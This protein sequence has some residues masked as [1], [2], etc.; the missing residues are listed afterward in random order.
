MNSTS[1][2]R[3]RW[4]M[5]YL[6]PLVAAA[7]LWAGSA[8]AETPHKQKPAAAARERVAEREKMV[9]SQIE[10]AR[11]WRTNVSDAKVLATRMICAEL[12]AQLGIE[13]PVVESP[14]E[15]PARLHLGD[16]TGAQVVR[17][18]LRQRYDILRDDALLRGAVLGAGGVKAR[19]RFDT[20]RR[21][22]RGRRELSGS[23]VFAE[24]DCDADA[25]LV[26]ALGCTLQ[27]PEQAL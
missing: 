11:D 25:A 16:V 18:L 13:L 17:S 27:S 15:P 26:R 24:V 22:Y 20:L 7:T 3:G 5:Y 4:I 1:T 12:A 10:S 8:L 19:E 21:D 6:A 14:L 9:T 23:P 2:T